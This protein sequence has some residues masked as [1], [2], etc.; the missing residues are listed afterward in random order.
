MLILY[1]LSRLKSLT[2]IPSFPP[3]VEFETNELIVSIFFTE[4]LYLD[5]LIL[6]KTNLISSFEGNL[7]SFPICLFESFLM[8]DLYHSLYIIST[9]L[10]QVIFG[11]FTTVSLY[12]YELVTSPPPPQGSQAWGARPVVR[13]SRQGRSPPGAVQLSSS[14][15]NFA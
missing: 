13:R 10:T 14:C 7:R 2:M 5:V 1:C 3:D 9:H 4:Y 6:L 15:H 12:K 11:F 8:I